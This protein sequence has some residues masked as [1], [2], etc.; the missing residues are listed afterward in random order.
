MSK[1]LID[2]AIYE[3]T[4]QRYVCLGW[5]SDS[6][7]NGSYAGTASSTPCYFRIGHTNGSNGGNAVD[8]NDPFTLTA[9]AGG[10]TQFLGIDKAY[11]ASSVKTE[12]RLNGPF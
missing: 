8:V 4:T 5:F 11:L 7:G 1:A 2:V 10:A 6:F 9:V 12:W 3:R